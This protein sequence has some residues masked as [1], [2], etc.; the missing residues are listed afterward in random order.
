M[1]QLA[2]VIFY[3]AHTCTYTHYLTVIALLL[4][5]FEEFKVKF[6]CGNQQHATDAIHSYS[7]KNKLLY[8]SK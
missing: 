6:V 7:V 2:L 5:T 8:A 3:K 1:A 4:Y